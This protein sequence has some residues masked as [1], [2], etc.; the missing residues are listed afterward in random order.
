M[1]RSD[2]TNKH[3]PC[4]RRRLFP[5]W[6]VA[7]SCSAGSVPMDDILFVP[8]PDQLRSD[9]GTPLNRGLGGRMGSLGMARAEATDRLAYGCSLDQP[10][11]KAGCLYSA[12][13]RLSG[14][15]QKWA[16]RRRYTE[17]S[18][19]WPEQDVRRRNDRPGFA[20]FEWRV[21]EN[22]SKANPMP[23]RRRA[24]SKT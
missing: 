4:G 13:P 20:S 5:V 7:I 8:C 1:A 9:S 15:R 24:R 6:F 23:C 11:R 17:R 14:L 16:Q 22:G 18:G 21:G 10:H 3:A 12:K 19:Q 2:D